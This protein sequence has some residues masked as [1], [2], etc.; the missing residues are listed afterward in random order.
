MS[1]NPAE[2]FPQVVP[3]L[4]YEDVDAAAEWLSRVFGYRELLRWVGPDG[5]MGHADMELE[6]GI[7]MLD[8]GGEGYRNPEQGAQ[9]SAYIVVWVDDVDAHFDRV[10]AAGGAIVEEPGDR[11]WGLRQYMVRDLEG[12][13]W[14]FTQHI[15]NVQPEEWGAEAVD[16]A[17]P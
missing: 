12:H 16:P 4:L 6:G 2:G 15:R 8:A 3:A 7:I 10:R 1:Y 17:Y 14:E 9:P 11:P 13:T 5:R